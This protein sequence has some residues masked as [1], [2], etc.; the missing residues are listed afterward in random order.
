MKRHTSVEK[1][2]PFRA[3]GKK[4]EKEKTTYCE[5][6]YRISKF[7][8]RQRAYKYF[9]IPILILFSRICM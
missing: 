9:T 7:D 3:F 6:T 8:T 5:I 1:E 4:K 2:N